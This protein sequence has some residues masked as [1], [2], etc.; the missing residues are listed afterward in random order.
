MAKYGATVILVD[1]SESVALAAEE[2][3]NM[4]YKADHFRVDGEQPGGCPENGRW[5]H[6]KIW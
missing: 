1:F 4:G 5:D 2:I 6:R 3:R